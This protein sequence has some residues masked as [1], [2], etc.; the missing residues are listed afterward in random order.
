MIKNLFM[1]YSS[2]KMWTWSFT[3]EIFKMLPD[4]FGLFS[5]LF[6]LKESS[7]NIAQVV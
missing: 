1:I 3:L 5:L 6:L 2:K 7:I 4:A